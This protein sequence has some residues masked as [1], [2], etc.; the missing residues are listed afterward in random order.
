M[1]HFITNNLFSKKQFGF[2]T[3][4]STVL[5]LL[6][7]LDKWTASLEEG[8]CI[9]AIYTD[10][11]KA[12]DKVPHKRLISKL[13]SYGISADIISWI[14]DFLCNRRQRVRIDGK[15][16]A[17]HRVLSGIPQ[18]SV[19][20]PLL[21]V[22]FI[23]DLAEACE[24]LADIYLFADDA[25]IFRHIKSPADNL[26]LQQTCDIVCN[27]SQRWLM[28]LNVTKCVLLRMGSDSKDGDFKYSIKVKDVTTVLERVTSTKDLGIIVDENLK[29]KE[30]IY[31]K[32]N[33]AFSILG[34]IKRNFRHMTTKT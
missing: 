33:K 18:G 24:G 6:N 1:E 17:W 30:H 27:W 16:S 28:P 12:F 31:S 2:I 7:I 21:F 3:G 22:I 23:N 20:G 10:F 25:K 5:Q 15:F 19:L 13:Q 9:D 8:G 11:E 34:I 26:T 14:K 32:I 29:F 4:R